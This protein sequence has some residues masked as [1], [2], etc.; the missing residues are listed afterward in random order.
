M[1][2]K[3]TLNVVLAN[4]IRVIRKIK[5]YSQEYMAIALDMSQRHYFRIENGQTDIKI[6]FL[7]KVCE[8]LEIKPIVLFQFEP[9]SI[10]ADATYTAMK[11]DLRD[12]GKAG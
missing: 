3:Q 6:T 10:F 5:G 8:I 11:N 9:D 12:L 4:R 1:L 2:K 7:Q